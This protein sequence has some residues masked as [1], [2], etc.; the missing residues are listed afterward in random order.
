MV[1]VHLGLPFHI[2]LGLH[3]C[4]QFLR[5]IFV[6]TNV[7]LDVLVHLFGRL[8]TYISGAWHGLCPREDAQAS[9]SPYI[10]SGTVL[11][12]GVGL[13]GTFH[14]LVNLFSHPLLFHSLWWPLLGGQGVSHSV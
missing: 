2:G 13:L 7:V 9:S 8:G 3:T 12:Q 5:K 14:L 10:L 11:T 6:N 4:H 1:G